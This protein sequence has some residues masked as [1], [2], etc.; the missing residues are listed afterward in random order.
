M[1]PKATPNTP[2]PTPAPIPFGPIVPAAF[3]LS[4]TTPPVESVAVS[5]ETRD[6]SPDEAAVGFAALVT[7]RALVP[8]VAV[9]AAEAG[10]EVEAYEDEG[11]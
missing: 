3:V 9:T 11:L 5:E 2:N 6:D 7:E 10:M 8:L 4:G 1:S